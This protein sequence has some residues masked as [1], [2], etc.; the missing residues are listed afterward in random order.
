MVP[1]NQGYMV[2]LFVVDVL[3]LGSGLT[4]QVEHF[5]KGLPISVELI[6]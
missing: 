1:G 6:P 5:S 3:H 4:F 2:S